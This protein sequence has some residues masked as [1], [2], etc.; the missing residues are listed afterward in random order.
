MC[1]SLP[2]I[3]GNIK[4]DSMLKLEYIRKIFENSQ[5]CLYNEWVQVMVLIYKDGELERSEVEEL[6][7]ISNY[8]TDEL[9]KL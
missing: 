2:S 3:L 4:D 8:I 1:I 6:F 7:N 9:G 5:I